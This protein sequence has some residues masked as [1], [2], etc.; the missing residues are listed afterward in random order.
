MSPAARFS[1]GFSQG[2]MEAKG[3]DVQGATPVGK[4]GDVGHLVGMIVGNLF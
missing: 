3:G 2:I 4:T 1:A